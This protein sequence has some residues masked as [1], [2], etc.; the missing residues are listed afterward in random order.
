M[1]LLPFYTVPTLSRHHRSLPVLQDSSSPVVGILS[2]PFRSIHNDTNSTDHYIAA[3]YVK[4]LEAGGARSIPIPFDADEQ[5]L[6]D[7]WP[8]INALLLPGGAADYPESVQL[9]LDMVVESNQ[10]GNY[11]PV[12]GTC[13]G[14]E[15]LIRY[16][17][18]PNAVQSGFAAENVSLALDDVQPIGLYGDTE[19]FD[20]V[21]RHNVTMNNHMSGIAPDHFRKNAALTANWHVTSTN[22]D[23]DGRRFVS[24]IEPVDP[25]SFPIYGVQYHPEKNAFEYASYPGT[26]IPYE[27]IDHSK[28]GVA[29]SVYTA[30]FFVDLARRS[31]YDNRQH[32]YTNDVYPNTYTYPIKTGLT[33]EQVYLIPTAAHWTN[34]T[35]RSRSNLRRSKPEPPLSSSLA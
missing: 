21:T 10:A 29:F 4:W 20:T 19:Q 24:T 6:N 7:I 14:F 35:D 11:F 25:E 34:H 33:F 12:W 5:L 16:V 15:F 28:A 8:Q 22:T 13:L 18:G 30:R 32:S 1:L 31:M 9:L 2:Q 26:N 3:S 17:G 27:A 23:L